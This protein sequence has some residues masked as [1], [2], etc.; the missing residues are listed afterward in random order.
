MLSIK[1]GLPNFSRRTGK[2]DQ[3]VKLKDTGSE[4]RIQHLEPKCD[5]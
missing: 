1:P 5:Q 3:A 4:F 2:G